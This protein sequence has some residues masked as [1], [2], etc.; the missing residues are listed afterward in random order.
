V[1][2][3]FFAFLKRKNKEP[4]TPWKIFYGLF[5]TALST[6]VMVAATFVCHNGAEKSSMLWLIG[7]YGVITVGELCLSPIGLS[8]VAK[9]APVR[10]SSL[11]MG[12]WFIAN[13]A[14]YALAG[15]LGALLPPTGDKYVKAQELGIDL[16][17]VLSGKVVATAD[18][19]RLL[20]ENNLPNAYPTFAGFAIHDLYEFF[21]LF[22]ILP[23]IAAGLLLMLTPLLKKMMHGV[24]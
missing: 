21:M 20:A 6:L 4:S 12:V 7:C 1:V 5:I 15:T 2:V 23:A 24:R 16:G 14:G 9:L 17:G 13:A 18:Q 8:L 22:V 19:L 11:L 3:A 10:F